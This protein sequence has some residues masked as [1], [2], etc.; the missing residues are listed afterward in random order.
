MNKRA[1]N[2]YNR[3]TSEYSLRADEQILL[4]EACAEIETIDQLSKLTPDL[5]TMRA[6]LS[7]R[8][9]LS[10]LLRR[11][12]LVD[13]SADGPRCSATSSQA[14]RAAMARWGNRQ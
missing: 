10:T 2:F 14:R 4:E 6:L 12:N 5:K 9:L 13:L 11:L 7:H 1:T 3:V 8:T